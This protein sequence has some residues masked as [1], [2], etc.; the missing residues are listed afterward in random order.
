MSRET[1][2][3]TWMDGK[4]ATYEDI[5]FGIREGCLHIY[6]ETVVRWRFPISNIR[7]WGPQPWQ[8][9]QKEVRDAP[10]RSEPR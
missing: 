6:D 1:I 7:A 3:V 10:V 2:V 5:T 4:I 8:T 9:T